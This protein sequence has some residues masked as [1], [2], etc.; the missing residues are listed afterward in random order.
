M[1]EVKVFIKDYSY[2]SLDEE[3]KLLVLEKNTYGYLIIKQI[4]SISQILTDLEIPHIIC[5]NNDI[6]LKLIQ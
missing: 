3:K 1:D 2:Y 6:Q 4:V 5:E